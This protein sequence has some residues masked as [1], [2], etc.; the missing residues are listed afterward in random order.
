M[1]RLTLLLYDVLRSSG[2]VKPRMAHATEEKLR[3]MLRRLDLSTSDSELWQ[4]ML[5]QIQWKLGAD[6]ELKPE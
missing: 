4:G 6:S 5:R 1:E 2:Y 3:R